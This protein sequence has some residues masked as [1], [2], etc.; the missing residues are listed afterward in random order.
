MRWQISYHIFFGGKQNGRPS[1]WILFNWCEHAY[2]FLSRRCNEADFSLSLETSFLYSPLQ[3]QTSDFHHTSALALWI[4][5]HRGSLHLETKAS[6]R[7]DI[8]SPSHSVTWY[9]NKSIS[10]SNDTK[11]WM[12]AT[13]ERTE[14][15]FFF[16]RLDLKW[17]FAGAVTAGGQ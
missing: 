14:G 9:L 15:F 8:F 17:F 13:T 7:H 3:I 11:N 1:K 16:S 6:I 2:R 5:S 10:V 12:T 4:S